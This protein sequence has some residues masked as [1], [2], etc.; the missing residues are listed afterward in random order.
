MR[1]TGQP[2][3]HDPCD[4]RQYIFMWKQAIEQ[5]EKEEMNW[6]LHTNAQSVLTQDQT[7]PNM[8]YEFLRSKQPISGDYY[9]HRLTEVLGILKELDVT[10]NEEEL[11]D[12][13]MQELH[14]LQASLRIMVSDFL[15]DFSYKILL[16][17]KRDME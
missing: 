2:N 10:I 1:C 13:I 5:R 4:L 12:R 11:S 9:A 17:V 16:N 3:T 6:L 7:I 14:E 15:D 8:S